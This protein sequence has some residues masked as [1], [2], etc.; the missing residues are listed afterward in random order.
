MTGIGAQSAPCIGR[1]DEY[2]NTNSLGHQLMPSTAE[3]TLRAMQE[4]VPTMGLQIWT[5]KATTIGE[6]DA[7]FAAIA[8]ERPDALFVGPD[9]FFVSRRV[10]LAT[11]AARERIPA[12]YASRD[13][14]AVGGLM[15]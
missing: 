8:R 14:I 11:L 1:I 4:A 9:G 3:S 15:S 6:I 13:H 2:G 5:L 10:Q 7:A 12:A